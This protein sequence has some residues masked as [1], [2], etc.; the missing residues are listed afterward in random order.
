MA[1]GTGRRRP[2]GC[3][4]WAAAGPESE[5]TE[6]EQGPL[7]EAGVNL[8]RALPGQGL[9]VWGARTLS[10]DDACKYLHVRRLVNFLSD[11][12]RSAAWTASETNDEHLRASLRQAVTS[13]L[14]DQW[15]QGTLQG[16]S[17]EEAFSVTCD[18]TNNTNETAKSGKVAVDVGVAVVR[19]AE[20]VRFTAVLAGTP[21]GVRKILDV[22]LVAPQLVVEVTVDVAR[23]AAGGM[24]TVHGVGRLHNSAVEAAQRSDLRWLVPWSGLHSPWSGVAQAMVGAAQW[25]DSAVTRCAQA[26]RTGPGRPRI[27]GASSLAGRSR[28]ACS[29]PP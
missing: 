22:V 27:P 1:S 17:A 29:R 13:F 4:S 24:R 10:T 19:P 6:A 21:G 15:H 5:P 23:G 12:I 7:K 8:L 3:W 16:S 11:S 14:T 28:R 26:S 18:D 2:T 25:P 20:F 9:V